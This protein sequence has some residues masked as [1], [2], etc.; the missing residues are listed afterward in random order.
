LPYP[1]GSFDHSLSMLMPQ[2]VPQPDLAVREMT[3]GDALQR[4]RRRRHRDD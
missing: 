4:S 2:F 3:Q 1:D